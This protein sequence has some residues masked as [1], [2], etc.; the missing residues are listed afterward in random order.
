MC[1]LEFLKYLNSACCVDGRR[2][3]ATFYDNDPGIHGKS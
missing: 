2:I 1:A 3:L